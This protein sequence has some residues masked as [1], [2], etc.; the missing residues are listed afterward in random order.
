MKLTA[1]NQ[2]VYDF[3]LKY[4]AEEDT[5]PTIKALSDGMGWT[6]Q[7]N[8]AYHIRKLIAIGLLE[9]RGC[10]YRFTRKET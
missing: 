2:K 9:K 1:L 7:T 4:H 3:I 5:V 10:S 6:H 8:S